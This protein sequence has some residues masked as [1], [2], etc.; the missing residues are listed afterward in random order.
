MRNNRLYALFLL[1]GVFFPAVCSADNLFAGIGCLSNGNC[2]LNDVTTLFVNMARII[3]GVTGSLALL[4]F[5]YGGILFLVSGGSSERVNK[6]KQILVG[7]S[8]GVVIVLAS[9]TIIEF[10]ITALGASA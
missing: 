10:V 4:A 1:L 6:A 3:L 9:Y 7:A 2:T 8:L 5:V